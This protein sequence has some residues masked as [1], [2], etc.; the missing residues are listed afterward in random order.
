M[1]RQHYVAITLRPK[2]ANQL[3]S[4]TPNQ[5]LC[6]SKVLIHTVLEGLSQSQICG[7][8]GLEFLQALPF[9]P[10]HYKNSF[11][12]LLRVSPALLLLLL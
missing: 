7:Y 9:L 3:S 12:R 1:L 10:S 5:S 2:A 4:D 11:L 6:H 8:A